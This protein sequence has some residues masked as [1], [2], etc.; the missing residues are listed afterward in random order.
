MHHID[1]GCGLKEFGAQASALIKSLTDRYG[2][3]A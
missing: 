1:A 2:E 3:S